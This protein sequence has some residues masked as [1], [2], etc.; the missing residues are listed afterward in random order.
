MHNKFYMYMYL[1]IVFI[2]YIDIFYCIALVCHT[3][4]DM[5]VNADVMKALT[6]AVGSMQYGNSS[7]FAKLVADACCKH[8]HAHTCII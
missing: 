6:T 7:F 3:V 5:K 1:T 8:L 4:K 2:Y